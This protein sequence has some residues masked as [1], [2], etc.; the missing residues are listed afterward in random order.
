M[1]G[2]RL[3]RWSVI[4]PSPIPSSDTCKTPTLEQEPWKKHR[5]EDR[6][7]IISLFLLLGLSLLLCKMGRIKP[8]PQLVL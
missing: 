6:R 7:F 5:I 1:W 8:H 3:D 2:N 4:M